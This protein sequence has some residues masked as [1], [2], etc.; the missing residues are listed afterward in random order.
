[1]ENKKIEIV[2][3]EAKRL[4]GSPYKYGAYL[5]ELGVEN[6]VFDCSSFIQSV[7]AKADIKIPRS[8]ILQAADRQGFE[9]C[10][11]RNVQAGDLVFFEGER[12]HY[13]HDLF[14]E[15]KL[16]IGH[17][18][19]FVGGNSI[20]HATNSNGFSGVI[21]QKIFPFENPLYNASTIVLIK[22]FF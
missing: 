9:V 15:K 21:E 20:I 1:M 3:E 13:R 7:F 14:P 17:V 18:A 12:G 22:R 5:D 8:T 4:I 10:G 19:L 16:Y 6:K 11:R 2:V